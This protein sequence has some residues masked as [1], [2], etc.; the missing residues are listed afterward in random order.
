M[1]F[2]PIF[3]IFFNDSCWQGSG[4]PLARS[5]VT[6]F[7]HTFFISFFSPKKNDKVRVM[8]LH[9]AVICYNAHITW[10]CWLYCAYK[11]FSRQFLTSFYLILF[12]ILYCSYYLLF[13]IYCNTMSLCHKCLSFHIILPHLLRRGMNLGSYKCS[14]TLKNSLPPPPFYRSCPLHYHFITLPYFFLHR[15]PRKVKANSF[16]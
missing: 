12:D 6:T 13:D 11:G 7:Y 9:V 3:M 10:P 8:I 5:I 1:V 15:K 4:C 14:N 16:L 2:T